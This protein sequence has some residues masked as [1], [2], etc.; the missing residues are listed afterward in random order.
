M[1]WAATAEVGSSTELLARKGL[2]QQWGGRRNEAS[3]KIDEN[4][5]ELCLDFGSVSCRTATDI[6][7]SL[8]PA[9]MISWHEAQGMFKMQLKAVVQNLL[10]ERNK[11]VVSSV[12]E[13]LSLEE[14][15][16]IQSNHQFIPTELHPSVPHLHRS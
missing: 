15:K 4:Q 5:Q 1:L 12:V 9:F 11:A 16:I 2:L 13:S 7:T 14:F 3:R 10:G 8:L 6:S